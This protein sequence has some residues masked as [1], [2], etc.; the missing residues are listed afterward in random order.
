MIWAALSISD[1]NE[2]VLHKKN[3]RLLLINFSAGSACVL[4][5]GENANGKQLLT[6]VA[7]SKVKYKTF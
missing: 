7:K 3:T 5:A 2:R 1:V 6:S 4:E